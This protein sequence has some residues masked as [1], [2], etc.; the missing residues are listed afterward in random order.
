MV[1]QVV[2]RLALSA[3]GLPPAGPGPP[4]ARSV[5]WS[6]D[7]ASAEPCATG[8]SAC[9]SIRQT[10]CTPRFSP[11]S[12]RCHPSRRSSRAKAFS[13]G[14]QRRKV[15]DARQGL[16]GTAQR[17]GSSG[18]KG[19]SMR[20]MSSRTWDTKRGWCRSPRYAGCSSRECSSHCRGDFG[21]SIQDWAAEAEATPRASSVPSTPRL[22]PLRLSRRLGTPTPRTRRA[23][24]PGAG[25]ELAASLVQRRRTVEGP[26]QTFDLATDEEAVDPPIPLRNQTAAHKSEVLK[27]LQAGMRDQTVGCGET[28]LE[29]LELRLDLERIVQQVVRS[30]VAAVRHDIQDRWQRRRR[31]G[32]KLKRAAQES[33][34]TAV[35]HMEEFSQRLEELQRSQEELRQEV[36]FL[37][38][39]EGPQVPERLTSIEEGTASALCDA[40]SWLA[41]GLDDRLDASASDAESEAE[42][43]ELIPASANGTRHS[44]S[45]W[46]D[47]GRGEV[48]GSITEVREELCSL[49]ES[50]FAAL[51]LK[52]DA[53]VMDDALQDHEAW[54]EELSSWLQQLRDREEAVRELLRTSLPDMRGELSHGASSARGSDPSA[55]NVGRGATGC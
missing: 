51:D 4:T 9:S 28:S 11:R 30:E 47:S 48:S 49:K 1:P 50:F 55:G 2:P 13:E 44:F 41:P 25:A 52:A 35:Q 17:Q 40:A 19:Q 53:S 16:P 18:R 45:H 36:S 12:T 23:C 14:R 43:E 3:L 42:S 38:C 32:K 34:F 15:S 39:N 54:M 20:D 46:A 21:D 8:R 6:E 7:E 10:P 33:N 24:C 29:V 5:R 26:L 31:S 37:L 27:M 22:P